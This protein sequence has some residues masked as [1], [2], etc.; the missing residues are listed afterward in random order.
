MTCMQKKKQVKQGNKTSLIVKV[1]GDFTEIQ[2]TGN[3]Q[4]EKTHISVT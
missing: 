4:W 2:L 1:S 3:L